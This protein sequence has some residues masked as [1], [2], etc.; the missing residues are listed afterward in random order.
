MLALREHGSSILVGTQAWAN[1]NDEMLELL[2]QNGIVGLTQYREGVLVS[3]R[4]YVGELRSP[5]GSVQIE[6]KIGR[7][8]FA[9]LLRLARR[10]NARTLAQLSPD[11]GICKD[12]A[13]R[14][15]VDEYLT[16]LAGAIT[17][18]LPIQ[19]ETR[20]D[21]VATPR[22]RIDFAKTFRQFTS[23]G[24]HHRVACMVFERN[25]RPDILMILRLAAEVLMGEYHLDRSQLVK[26]DLCMRQV[27][28]V[29]LE[30]TAEALEA[31]PGVLRDY[32]SSS[33][34]LALMGSARRVL[35]GED[36]ALVQAVEGI[37]GHGRFYDSDLLWEKALYGA[38]VSASGW[39]GL[40]GALHPWR[41]SRKPL[42]EDGGP[43][44]DP[45]ILFFEGGDVRIVIDAKNKVEDGPI[46]SDVYQIVSYAMR[47]GASLAI[48]AYM[49]TS[50]GWQQD[51]GD[52]RVRV[53][54]LGL[55][56]A[57]LERSCIE[58]AAELVR[59]NQGAHA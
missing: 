50:S 11:G 41:G 54:C 20:L 16:L 38:L 7:A 25:E 5:L 55:P 22:G 9:A 15:I 32:E 39:S 56:L 21:A 58:M 59:S 17:D 4:N 37:A 30:S 52:D 35:S 2:A 51:F 29:P 49:T 13:E 10:N 27:S 18:G 46:A 24:I 47:T 6:P 1:G 43:D 26:L 33:S 12:G 44:L 31:I 48:L 19:Y 14:D 45:D 3:P 57:T 42:F 36:G 28:E 53:I 8:P 23:R 40:T 34:L